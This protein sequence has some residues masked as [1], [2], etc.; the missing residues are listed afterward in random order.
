M[1]RCE[2][3]RIDWQSL[4]DAFVE[5][6]RVAKEAPGLRAAMGRRAMARMHDL[7]A[8]TVIARRLRAH[9]EAWRAWPAKTANAPLLYE[10]EPT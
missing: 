2:H 9:L 5:S 8:T 7:T 1:I 10:S 3:Y 6:Y 4:R